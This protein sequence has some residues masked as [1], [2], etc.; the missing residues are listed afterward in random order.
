MTND[1]DKECNPGS[2]RLTANLFAEVPVALPE[3]WIETLLDGPN[4]RIERIVSTGH[5]SPSGFWYDQTESEWVVVLRGEATLEFEDE[6]RI[7]KPGDY[8]FIPPHRKHRVQSTSTAEPTVWLAVFFGNK[9]S[10]ATS[11]AIASNVN[12]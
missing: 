4:V 9:A 5:T 8:V 1:F 3:E 6:T 12:V 7:L 10:T 11:T 2:S